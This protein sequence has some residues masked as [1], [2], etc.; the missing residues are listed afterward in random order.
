MSKACSVEVTFVIDE[1]LCLVFQAPER[2]GVDHA[3]SVALELAAV[4][5]WWL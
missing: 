4:L 3:V 1:H 5:G 2:A